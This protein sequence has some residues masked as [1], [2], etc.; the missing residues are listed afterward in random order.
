MKEVVDLVFQGGSIYTGVPGPAP[1]AVAVAGGRIVAVGDSSEI[2]N[3]APVGTEVIDLSGRLLLPGFND[4]HVHPI[5]GG[6]ERLRCDLSEY[7]GASAYKKAIADYVEAN[8]DLE[9]VFG[10]G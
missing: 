5:A 9:W 4:A 8:P 1:E 7:F 3:L 2:R 6:L 10:A